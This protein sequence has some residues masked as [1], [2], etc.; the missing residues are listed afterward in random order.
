MADVTT[1]TWHPG[2]ENCGVCDYPATREITNGSGSTT[3]VCDNHVRQGCG[4]G[5]SDI[6]DGSHTYMSHPNAYSKMLEPV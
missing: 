4:Q 6:G 5:I 3:H 1:M 2:M